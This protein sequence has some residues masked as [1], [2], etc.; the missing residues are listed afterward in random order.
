[1]HVFP[2]ET[3]FLECVTSLLRTNLQ[4]KSVFR[5]LRYQN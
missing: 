5:I 3:N 2:A 4:K 1:M